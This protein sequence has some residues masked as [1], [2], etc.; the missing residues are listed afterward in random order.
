MFSP[1]VSKI[2][3]EYGRVENTLADMT[4]NPRHF[5]GLTYPSDDVRKDLKLLDDFKHT[6]ESKELENVLMQNC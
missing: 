3:T 6:P 4:P 1:N 5:E 2:K